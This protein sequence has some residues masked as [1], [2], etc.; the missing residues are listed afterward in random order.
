MLLG[1]EK[2][3]KIGLH[4]EALEKCS[5]IEKGRKAEKLHRQFAHALKEKLIFLVRSSRV[6]HDKEFLDLIKNVWDSYSVCLRLKRPPLQPL[7]ELALGSRFNDSICLDL[8][9]HWYNLIDTSTRYSAAKWLKQKD[10]RNYSQHISNVNIIF[11]SF[12]TVFEWQWV[13][14]FNNEVYWQMNEKLN[15]ETGT[16]AAENLFNNGTVEHCSLE[17]MLEDE[18]CEPEIVLAWAVSTQNALQNYSGHNPNDLVFGPNVQYTL[19]FNLYWKL[20]Q[21]VTR[22]K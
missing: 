19:G 22:L 8:K 4:F 12:W 11:W 14:G 17:K 20:Q 2:L 21:S 5:R 7:V 15:I 3:P 9:E 10:C 1:A 13:G 6:F 16:T 18:K